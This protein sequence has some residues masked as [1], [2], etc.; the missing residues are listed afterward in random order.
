[1]NKKIG[2]IDTKN[3]I[4]VSIALTLGVIFLISYI[5]LMSASVIFIVFLAAI[6]LYLSKNDVLTI[7]VFANIFFISLLLRFATQDLFV[8]VAIGGFILI[9][10]I[11]VIFASLNQLKS[12]VYSICG[13]LFVVQCLFILN[14]AK[15]QNLGIAVILSALFLAISQILYNKNILWDLKSYIY[16]IMFILIAIPIVI[17]Y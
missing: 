6:Y 17:F 11:F 3:I 8:L 7:S 13:S 16:C 15:I 10:N 2:H 12:I 1:M 14:S 9:I 4:V 5:N